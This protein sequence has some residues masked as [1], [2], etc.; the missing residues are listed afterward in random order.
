MSWLHHYY[1]PLGFSLLITLANGYDYYYHY[2]EFD[3]E[4]LTDA[5]SARKDFL[6]VA[7][8]RLSSNI[9]GNVITGL[10]LLEAPNGALAFIINNGLAVRT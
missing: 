10:T 2:D 9:T 6:P 1:L 3:N 7:E 8:P 4:V 5:G